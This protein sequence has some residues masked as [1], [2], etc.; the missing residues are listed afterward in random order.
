[1]YA[2]SRTG[3]LLALL[4]LSLPVFAQTRSGTAAVAVWVPGEA[5]L[6]ID[7]K[8]TLSGKGV[9]MPPEQACKIRESGPFF[10]AISGLYSHPTTNFDAWRLAAQAV[11]GAA[12][13]ADAA[14]RVERLIQPSLRRALSDI[15]QRNPQD[16]ARR[17]S[18][19]WLI[20]WIA[21][22]ENGEPVMA[23]REF[24]P[25][26]TVA[27]ELP[28]HAGEG[29]RVDGGIAIF[30]E[31]DAIDATY[32]DTPVLGA[33]LKSNGAVGAARALVQVEIDG[34]PQRA[35]APISVVRIT[36]VHP[37][38]GGPEWLER[39]LCAPR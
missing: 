24:L 34:E 13:V 10:Y 38:T 21:G 16:Y 14:A 26:K 12:S 39:G 29:K 11:E 18:R 4:V 20:V 2:E 36:T 5:V 33:L 22:T 17:Y 3:R 1:V 27:R 23:G 37:N 30:G 25:E 7:S 15:R 32:A 31:R 8:V 19:V 35:G 28:A 6:A 9:N